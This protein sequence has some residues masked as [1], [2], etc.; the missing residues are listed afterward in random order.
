MSTPHDRAIAVDAAARLIGTSLVRDEFLNVTSA[1]DSLALELQVKNFVSST[2]FDRYS[3]MLIRDDFSS[4][5]SSIIVGQI[6]NAPPEYVDYDDREAAKVDP[7]MQYCKRSGAPIAYGQSTY[8][9]AGLAEKWEHQAPFGF[10]Y[11][12]ALAV[13]LP[14]HVHVFFGV[15]RRMPLPTCRAELTEL[16]ARVHLFGTFVQCTAVGLL[17]SQAR[18]D[19]SRH[20]PIRLSPREHE[21]LQWA[22]EGKTAW[23]TGMILS[24]AEGSVVKILASAVRKLECTNKPHAVV[25]ALRLGLIH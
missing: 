7:V 4:S 3:V 23:E 8:I 5:S 6:N 11:G 2:G 21:C 10:G 12:V 9:V 22:A 20:S 25:K 13:H 1:Q 17:D 24:I 14:D 18:I 15:D 16:V 19:S